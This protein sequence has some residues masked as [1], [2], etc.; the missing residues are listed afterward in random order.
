MRRPENSQPETNDRRGDSMRGG[1]HFCTGGFGG[2]APPEGTGETRATSWRREQLPTPPSPAEYAT[3]PPASRCNP[4][5]GLERLERNP[6]SL[7]PAIYL[8]LYN[9]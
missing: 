1:P 4:H 7:N 5:T 9:I 6:Y 2:I 3:R 8:I